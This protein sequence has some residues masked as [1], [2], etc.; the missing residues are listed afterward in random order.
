MDTLNRTFRTPVVEAKGGGAGGGGV[1]V[2]PF[3][4]NLVACYQVMEQDARQLLALRLA[5]LEE[6][7]AATAT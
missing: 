6:A 5:E 7:L 4:A 1:R 2:T 3:G